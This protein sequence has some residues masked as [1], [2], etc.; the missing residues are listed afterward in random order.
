MWGVLAVVGG[1]RIE[2]LRGLVAYIAFDGE[3]IDFS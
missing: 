3:R 2:L 1:G